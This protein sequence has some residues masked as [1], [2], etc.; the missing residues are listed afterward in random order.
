[1]A[2]Y[3][4][5]IIKSITTFM[6]EVIPIL[7]KSTKGWWRLILLMVLACLLVSTYSLIAH[8]DLGKVFEQKKCVQF[9]YSTQ[10]DR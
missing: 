10:C 1:M 3:L 9:G 6:T 8:I 7:D 5:E 4:A 2:Q